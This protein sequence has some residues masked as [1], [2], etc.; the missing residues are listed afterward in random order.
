MNQFNSI[1]FLIEDEE[2]QNRMEEK[3]RQKI[4]KIIEK[5]ELMSHDWD[6]EPIP[7]YFF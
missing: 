3:L 7:K 6:N 1:F 5:G 4:K 2:E